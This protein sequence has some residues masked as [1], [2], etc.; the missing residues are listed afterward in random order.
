MEALKDVLGLVISISTV[1]GIFTGIIN[2]MFGEKLAPL[3]SRIKKSEE[4]SMKHDLGQLRYLIV[5]FSNDLRNGI[6]KS[7]FQYDAV[8]SFIDEYETMIEELHIKNGLFEEEKHYI[9]KR[10][11]ELIETN[12]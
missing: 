5:S 2:K 12:K 8:F 11:Q 6:P 9:Q 1:L 10:Y 7:R 3:E 4:N